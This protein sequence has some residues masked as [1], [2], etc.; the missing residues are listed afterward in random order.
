MEERGFVEERILGSKGT[1]SESTS[2]V[3]EAELGRERRISDFTVAV[4]R[5]SGEG[6]IVGI[7]ESGG[8]GASA[9]AAAAEVFFVILVQLVIVD[10]A[11]GGFGACSC[12]SVQLEAISFVV[13]E[14][15]EE[16][17]GARMDKLQS[18]KR[19]VQREEKGGERMVNLQ[20]GKRKRLRCVK[21]VK[22]SSVLGE[23]SAAAVPAAG[24]GDGAVR[25]ETPSR[26][27][28]SAAADGNRQICPPLLQSPPRLSRDLGTM[29]KSSSNDNTKVATIPYSPEKED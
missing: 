8:A 20:W 1:S 11:I 21:V 18:E 10:H 2:L 9:K 12:E 19:K 4:G 16:K 22:D 3:T 27:V 29:N 6:E 14:Q 28:G 13:E 24:V 25:M 23:K 17:G 26:V 15:R 5:F 7:G